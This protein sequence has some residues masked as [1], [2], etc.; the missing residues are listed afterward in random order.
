[1]SDFKVDDLVFCLS[2]SNENLQAKVRNFI[3]NFK[4]LQIKEENSQMYYF[5]H[6]D[7][8]P[9]RYDVRKH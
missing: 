4:I 7:G 6:L 5:I 3:I 1:M 9:K 2:P 8:F